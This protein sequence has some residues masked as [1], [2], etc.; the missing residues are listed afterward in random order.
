LHIREL[1]DEVKQL[2]E[3]KGFG[4]STDTFWEKVAL[5]HTELSEL[6]D[7]VKKQGFDNRESIADEVADVIIRTMNFG[8][9]FDIDIE[10]AIMKKMSKNFKR[11]HMYN[12]YGGGGDL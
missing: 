8:A 2:L 1:Q 9:M 7:V 5:A 12:T 6:A 4:Y 10:N 3:E 11:P